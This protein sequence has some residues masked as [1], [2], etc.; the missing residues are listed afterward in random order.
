[1][2]IM[3]NPARTK[4]FPSL[5]PTAKATRVGGELPINSLAA[6]CQK[7]Q[8]KHPFRIATSARAGNDKAIQIKW[9]H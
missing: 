1:M 7:Q 9:L 4:Y 8:L 3:R 5:L 2:V 6:V